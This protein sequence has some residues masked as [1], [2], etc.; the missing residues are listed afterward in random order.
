MEYARKPGYQFLGALGTNLIGFGFAG[1]T[2]R[3]LIYPAYCVWP[4][5]LGTIAVNNALHEKSGDKTP[6]KGPFGTSWV[7]S[8]WKCFWVL[9]GVEFW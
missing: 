8:M 6:V 5:S 9:F 3:F 2:R 4:G 7:A 1:L